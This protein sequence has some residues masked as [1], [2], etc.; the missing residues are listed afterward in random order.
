M[1]ITHR[2]PQPLGN[3]A[4]EREIPTFPQPIIV[5]CNEKRRPKKERYEAN[6][7]SHTKILTLP[8]RLKLPSRNS[9]TISCCPAIYSM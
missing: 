4:G 7:V 9:A 8:I 3:L 1:E 2:F 5:V 6:H